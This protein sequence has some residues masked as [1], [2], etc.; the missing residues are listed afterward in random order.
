MI[1]YLIGGMC[2]FIFDRAKNKMMGL[3]INRSVKLLMYHPHWHR[4][5]DYFY[6]FLDWVLI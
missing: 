2:Y 3:F 5:N 6:K 1:F 4:Q